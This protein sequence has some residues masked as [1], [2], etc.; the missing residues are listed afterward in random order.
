M[1]DEAS[2]LFRAIRMYL[3]FGEFIDIFSYGK[4]MRAL[5][6]LFSGKERYRDFPATYALH[7]V[8]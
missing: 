4:E 5:F 8:K 2:V 7:Q 3:V 1:V 6:P